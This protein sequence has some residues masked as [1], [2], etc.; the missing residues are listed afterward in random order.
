[1]LRKLRTK[2]LRAITD[3]WDVLAP[4]R[5]RQITSGS[6]LSFKYIL[7][8]SILKFAQRGPR[9]VI[10]D[11]GCGVGV[12]TNLLADSASE[13]IGID[14]SRVSISIAQEHSAKNVRFYEK[15]IEEFAD[16]YET[17]ADLVV[18]NMVLMDVLNL[19]T[20]LESVRRLLR[21]HGKFVFS[22]THP[23]FWP[24]Y[25]GYAK[26]RWFHYH[27]EILIESP[28]RISTDPNG[29][30]VSTHIHRPLETYFHALESAGLIW[31]KLAEPMPPHDIAHLYP[32]PWAFPRY[33]IGACITDPERKVRPELDHY[34]S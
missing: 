28:F 34:Q 12:L 3:E 14:P 22:I 15:T 10:V 21:P 25:Y 4:I 17:I 24:E 1:M 2:T 6:D 11:A 31:E 23:W 32:K 9:K 18:A 13:I 30:F 7:A 16:E 29:E 20:F 8:P 5:Y 19:D 33:L 27:R 26:K